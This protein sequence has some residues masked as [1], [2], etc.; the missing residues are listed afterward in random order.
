MEEE[1][2]PNKDIKELQDKVVQLELRMDQI[3][4]AYGS[5]QDK[6]QMLESFVSNQPFTKDEGQTGSI[7]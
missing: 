5:M 7:Q 4:R 2:K 1:N 3:V 6:V